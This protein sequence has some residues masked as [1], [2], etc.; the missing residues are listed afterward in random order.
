MNRSLASLF[1]ETRPLSLRSIHFPSDIRLLFIGPHPDDFDAVGVTMRLLQANGN[2]IDVGVVRTSSG[3]QDSYCSPATI[4][5]KAAIR[6]QEQRRSCRFFGLSDT[7]LAFLRLE[8]D[9]EAHPAMTQPNIDCLQDFVR[10]KQPDIVLMPHGND[11]NTGHQRLYAMVKRVICETGCPLTAFLNR[12]PKTIDMRIDL[13]T[14]FGEEDA[15]WK[16][17]LLRFHDSQHQRNLNTRNHGFD[18]RILSVNRQ[19]A[20]EIRTGAKYAEAFELELFGMPNA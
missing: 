18:D 3:V 4:E 19:I 6:E 1:P 7:S 20:Q 11:T 13:Y 9:A 14:E 17:Q 10:S 15:R 16:A 5:L 8:E 2:S 12:D